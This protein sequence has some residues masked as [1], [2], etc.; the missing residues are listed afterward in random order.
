MR[1]SAL[2]AVVAGLGEIGTSGTLPASLPGWNAFRKVTISN[3][4]GKVFVNAGIFASD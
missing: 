3:G 1:C 2:E 4:A